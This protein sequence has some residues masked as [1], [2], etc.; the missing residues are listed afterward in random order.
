MSLRNLL[1]PP[2]L[3][4][5]LGGLLLVAAAGLWLGRAGCKERPPK[6][7]PAECETFCK[8]LV[9]CFAQRMQNFSMNVKEDTEAC[10][11]D[12][13]GKEGQSHGQI[14]RAMKR[15]G[16]LTDCKQLQSCFGDSL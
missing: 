3:P 5:V 7:T 11:R 13:Q 12:C 1:R 10:I 9:P 8:R 14:L 4:F 15:C 16:H 2:R 6:L